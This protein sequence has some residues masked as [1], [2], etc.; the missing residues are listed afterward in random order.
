MDSG[1]VVMDGAGIDPKYAARRKGWTAINCAS[2]RAYGCGDIG[3]SAVQ[4]LDLLLHHDG[5]L[6]NLSSSSSLSVRAGDQFFRWIDQLIAAKGARHPSDRGLRSKVEVVDK[7]LIVV[8]LSYSLYAGFDYYLVFDS[9]DSSLSMI[10]YIP[11]SW[12]T[13]NTKRPL[14]L[15]PDGGGG[16]GYTLFLFGGEFGYARERPN[17]FLWQ[18]SPT[19][20]AWQSKKL[21]FPSEIKSKLFSPDLL[22]SC[23]GCAFWTDLALGTLRCDCSTLLSDCHLVKFSFISLPPGCQLERDEDTWPVQVFR[24]MGY[25]G[26]SVK[27]VAI[28]DPDD[29]CDGSCVG[30]LKVWTLAPPSGRDWKLCSD[31][32]LKKLCKDFKRAGLPNNLPIWPMLREQEGFEVCVAGLLILECY[33]L[34]SFAAE[35]HV[36]VSFLDSQLALFYR[37]AKHA[38]MLQKSYVLPVHVSVLCFEDF[39]CND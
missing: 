34:L 29:P 5:D 19:A 1:F 35:L 21:I 7:G 24:T 16:G 14:P 12:A 22:F 4:D 13:C 3:N 18:W 37:N 33:Q 25:A 38:L 36:R 17:K 28:D 32:K 26:G 2:K 15:R 6:D 23:N 39:I 9:L 30:R 8:S 27:F 10:P 11:H 20:D 31:F